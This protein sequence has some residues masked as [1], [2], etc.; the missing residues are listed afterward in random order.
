MCDDG[1]DSIENSISNDDKCRY[2]M[3]HMSVWSCLK[4]ACYKIE[5]EHCKMLNDDFLSDPSTDFHDDLNNSDNLF[6]TVLL[7]L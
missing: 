7:T 5:F 1:N 4:T 3:F 2:P 6:K